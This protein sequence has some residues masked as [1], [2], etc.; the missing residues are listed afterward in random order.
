MK[1]QRFNIHVSGGSFAS[2]ILCFLLLLILISGSVFS[3]SSSLALPTSL[4]NMA[5][6]IDM[7]DAPAT[8]EATTDAPQGNDNGDDDGGDD[9]PATTDT[10]TDGPTGDDRK[11][12]DRD[13]DRDD[14]NNNNGRDYQSVQDSVQDSNVGVSGA[15]AINLGKCSDPSQQHDEFGVCGP[16]T[17]LGDAIAV[18]AAGD[19][20][21]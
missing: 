11:D 12:D 3:T 2:V 16:V 20:V 21:N 9:T 1:S 8:T 5:F 10:I 19:A 17:P 18:D 6:A 14:D 15:E 7:K 13:D 4:L